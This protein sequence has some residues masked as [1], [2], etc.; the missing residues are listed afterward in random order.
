MELQ[1]I[2]LQ[3]SFEELVDYV[4]QIESEQVSFV[5]LH[6]NTKEAQGR[7]MFASAK[8]IVQDIYRVMLEVEKREGQ[9]VEVSGREFIVVSRK[10]EDISR[11]LNNHKSKGSIFEEIEAVRLSA[12]SLDYAWIRQPDDSYLR[13]K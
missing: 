10:V 3:L 7:V 1:E 9:H 5:S 12:N 2:P 11:L 6:G 4:S 13:N 8:P